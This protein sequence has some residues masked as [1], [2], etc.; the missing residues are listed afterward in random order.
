MQCFSSCALR[1]QVRP[2]ALRTSPAIYLTAIISQRASADGTGWLAVTALATVA[3][4]LATIVFVIAAWRQLPIL[5]DQRRISVMPLPIM[6]LAVDQDGLIWLTLSNMAAVPALDIAVDVIS[7]FH[8]DDVPLEELLTNSVRQSDRDHVAKNLA[9]DDD[10]FY[11]LWDWFTYQVLAPRTRVRAPA[12]T[13]ESPKVPDVTVLL[14][15][16]DA[17]GH[18]YWSLAWFIRDE[19]DRYRC[20]SLRPA[21]PLPAPRMK[22]RPLQTEDGSPLPEPLRRFTWLHDHAL[23]AVFLDGVPAGHE[24][25]R[26]EWEAL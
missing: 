9:A 7:V 2:P 4:A 18:N 24:D 25:D 16:R 21:H 11:A 26:G 6:G 22:G 10:G 12:R 14:Q 3:L 5:R 13:P 20:S 15:Y 19:D 17:L 23:H 8:V 1:G